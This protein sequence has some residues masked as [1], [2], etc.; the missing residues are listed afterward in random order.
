MLK[1]STNAKIIN[2][3]ENKILKV[4]SFEEFITESWYINNCLLNITSLRIDEIKK[5]KEI[6]FYGYFS[7]NRLTNEILNFLTPLNKIIIYELEDVDIV[8]QGDVIRVNTYNQNLKVLYRRG[9]NSNILFLTERCNSQCIMCSQPPKKR[10][11][12]YLFHESLML[13]DLV[14]K[15]DIAIG[16]SGGEPTLYGEHLFTLINKCEEVLPNTTLHI[17]TNA[18]LLDTDELVFP[19]KK[20][21]HKKI[22]WGVPLFSSNSESH[23]KLVGE[24]GAFSQT[25]SGLYN[26]GANN[27]KIELRLILL[28]PV[29]DEIEELAYF[30]S[31]SLPFVSFVSLMGIEPIGFAKKNKEKIWIDPIDY[32]HKL[33]NTVNYL[34]NNKI[35]C[36]IFNL[37]LCTI[38]DSIRKFSVKSIS[39][40]KVI[41]QDECNECKE[42]NNCNGF[43]FSHNKSWNSKLI[44]KI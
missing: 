14:D 37:P 13:I 39:D 31:R 3:Y 27:Q 19:L 20:M 26:L 22:L 38:P 11:D 28:K 29:I 23:D 17:L 8:S 15:N 43:F 44:K 5:L 41:Y 42:K 7:K 35:Y 21:S 40:W 4:I 9:S 33:V 36:S 18:R 2:K 24:K 32:G 16:I 34:N 10:D 1:L 25:I 12:S 30:I 6:P